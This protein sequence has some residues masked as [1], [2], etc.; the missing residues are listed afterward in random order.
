MAHGLPYQGQGAH[1]HQEP[2]KDVE[3][4]RQLH[5]TIAIYVDA[6]KKAD[7]RGGANPYGPVPLPSP[8]DG[9]EALCCRQ[10]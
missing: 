9:I 2:E 4:E 3:H 6:G 10:I 8:T 5:D 1:I 7:E